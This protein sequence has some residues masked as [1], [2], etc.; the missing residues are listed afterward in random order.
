MAP[1]AYQHLHFNS[2]DTNEE[3]YIAGKD[4]VA[5]NGEMPRDEL[6]DLVYDDL[7]GRIDHF[8]KDKKADSTIREGTKDRVREALSVITE[9]LHRYEYPSHT[10]DG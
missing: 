7:V 4:S 1:E 10:V 8:L 2:T 6:V 3:R 5:M 9:A